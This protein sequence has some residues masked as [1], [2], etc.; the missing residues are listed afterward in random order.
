MRIMVLTYEFYPTVGGLANATVQ[1][2]DALQKASGHQV[3]VVVCRSWWP[4]EERR[5]NEEWRGIQIRRIKYTGLP[6]ERLFRQTVRSLVC[7]LRLMLVTARLRPDVIISQRVY[8]LGIFGGILGSIFRSRTV[9]YAHGPDEIDH[10]ELLPWRKRLNRFAASLNTHV[11]ATNTHHATYL[12]ELIGKPVVVIPN[13]AS[14]PI[15]TEPKAARDGFSLSASAYNI[16]FVGRLCREHGVETKGFSYLLK[17]VRELPFVHL[18]VVGEGPLRASYEHRSAE[19][20]LQDRVVFHGR[21]SHEEVHV[22][23]CGTDVLVAP[24]LSEGCSLVIMEA[25]MLL[26]PVIATPVG[27]ITDLVRDRQTGLWVKVRD[28]HSIIGAVEYAWR[29]PKEMKQLAAAARAYVETYAAPK[30]VAEEFERLFQMRKGGVGDQRQ[31]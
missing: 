16:L 26:L 9:A 3:S 28:S 7:L 13:I 20:G 27:G 17:A 10:A 1:L 18:H 8:D 12:S 24:S 30:R 15:R 29:H 5:Y 31:K 25:M 11:V 22:I 4:W 19:L 6:E 2:C 21:L 23:M 14:V